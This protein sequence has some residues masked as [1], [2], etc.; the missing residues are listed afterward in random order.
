VLTVAHVSAASI[1]VSLA[2][3]THGAPGST[4][5]NL[6]TEGDLDWGVF[7]NS[8]LAPSTRMSGG[9]G[10][11]SMAYL[12]GASE[13][14]YNFYAQNSYSWTNGDSP[15]SGSENLTT[16]ADLGSNG[17]GIRSTFSIATAGTYRLKFYATTSDTN[18]SAIASLASGG[19]T[20]TA[21]GIETSGL[22]KYEFTVD[23][24]TDGS[25]TLTLDVVK[26]GGSIILAYEA[27]TLAA[28]EVVP[29]PNLNIDSDFS[30][31]NASTAETFQIPYSNNGQ[32][33]LTVSGVTVG[34]TDAAYFTVASYDASL[35]AGV[36]G[37]VALDF[38][39]VAGD[40]VYNATLTIASNDS[41]S[42]NTVVNLSVNSGNVVSGCVMDIFIV[43]GQSNA[44]GQGEVSTLSPAQAAA[45]DV[46][47]FCSWHSEGYNAETQQYFSDWADQTEAGYT[48]AYTFNNNFG[49]GGALG[50]D[51]DAG[52]FGPSSWFGPEVGFAARALELNLTGGNQLGIIKY[53]VDGSGLS[54]ATEIVAASDWDVSAAGYRQGDAW[55][56]FQ[57]AI[58]DAVAKLEADGISPNFKGMIWWQGEGGTSTPALNNFITA[59]RAHLANNYGLE[60]PLDFPVVITTGGKMIGGSTL[61]SGVAGIDDDVTFVNADHY[62]QLYQ[63]HV[64]RGSEGSSDHTGNGVNDMYDIGEAYAEALATVVEPTEFISDCS[65]G[66]NNGSEPAPG[67][68]YYVD[69]FMATGQSNAFYPNDQ[70]E[71]NYYGLGRGAQA[72]LSASGLF[73]NPTVVM[74]GAPGWAIAGWGGEW[75]GPDGGPNRNYQQQFFG[76]WDYGDGNGP[77][78]AAL[79]V[80]LD[81]IIAAGNTP[82]FRGLFWFQGES[83]GYG[84]YANNN[85]P[86]QATSQ[87]TY[88]L[89]WNGILEQLDADLQAAG[90]DHTQYKF[91]V[92]TVAESGSTINNILN[93]IATSG[94]YN[95][96]G[97]IYDAINSPHHGNNDVVDAYGD[98]HDYDHYAVGQANAQLFIDTYPPT[99]TSGYI[100]TSINVDDSITT[101]TVSEGVVATPPAGVNTATRTFTG[102]PTV[103][104]ATAAATYTAEYTQ[105]S[106][107][108]DIVDLFIAT[109]Q[110]NAYWPV[111]RDGEVVTGT[112]EFGNG[113]KDALVASGLFSNPAV[114]IDGQPGQEIAQWYENGTPQWLYQ[115][116][117]FG[118]YASTTAGLEAKI[119]EIIANGD[120]PRFRG[121]FWF[122]GESDGE[123]AG[124]S[125]T[126]EAVYTA[127]WNGILTQLAADLGS[128]D[129]NFVMNTV[130]NSGTR[131]N[132]TLTNITNADSRGV[133]FDTQVAPYRTNS[134]DIHG[135]DHYAVGQANAQL[136]IDTFMKDFGK[137]LCVGDSITEGSATRPAG[138]GN[139]SWRYAFW[140]QLVDN[141]V[142]YEFVGTSTYNHDYNNEEAFSV[143]P[144]YEGESFVNRHE[145]YW[146]LGAVHLASSLPGSLSTLK[147]Q[148]ETPDTAVV[149]L[150]GND[151]FHDP[152]V[153]AETVRDRIKTIVDTL[154]G[155]SG[156]NGNPNISVLLVS[157]LPRFTIDGSGNYTVP[158]TQSDHFT[159][160][161]NLLES[162]A[163]AESTAS[164]TVTYL[165]LATTF[166][167]TADVFYDGVHPNGTGE[168]LIADGIYSALNANAG[169]V[170][171]PATADVT[172]DG[173]GTDNLWTTASNWSGNTLPVDGDTVAIAN[174]DTVDIPGNYWD[175]PT[176]V[177][178]NV[179]GNSQIVNN[180]AAARLYGGMTFNFSSGS[181]M[182]GAY[183]DLQ[184]GILNF[185]DGA[186]FTPNS[187]QHRLTTI[188]GLTL[189]STGFTTLTPGILRQ[190]TDEDWG[191]VTF[192]LD[193]S[194]YEVSNGTTVELIDYSGH[195]SAYGGTFNPTVNLTAGDSGL[196]GTLSFDTASSKVIYTF[197]S[198]AVT[199]TYTITFINVDDTETTQTVD[200]GEVATPPAGVDTATRTFTGWP[201]I[202]A[203]TADATYTALYDVNAATADVIWD[204]G[205]AD[206]LWTTAAN[207][208]GDTL[209][210]TGDSVLVGSSAT[211]T[212][213]NANFSSLEIASG[214][215]VSFADEYPSNKTFNISGVLDR[216]A[217]NTVLR[218][219]GSVFNL[220]SS[221]SFGANIQWMDLGTNSR[222]SFAD[223]ASFATATTLELRG[224][225]TFDFTL[226]AT[227]FTTLPLGT[228]ADGGTAGWSDVTFN[229]DVSAYDTSNGLSI[230]LMDFASHTGDFGGSF[231]P[232]VNV[233]DGGTG[234]GAA[235]SFDAATSRII[236][237]IDA[238]GNDAPVAADISYAADG[239]DPVTITLS[240]TDS[241]SDP[242]TYTVVSGPSAGTLSGAAPNLIYTY[243]GSSFE[244]DSFTFKANDGVDDS[245]IA[246]VSI[247]PVPQNVGDLWGSL[248]NRIEN[249][250]LNAGTHTTWTEAHSNGSGDTITISRITYELGTLT[251]TQNSATPVIAGYY[252]RPTGGTNLPGL[253]QNH[254]G[255]QNA[256]SHYAKYL[257]EQ[258][259]AA[260]SIN[261]GGY[262][263]ENRNPNE[264]A[265]PEGQLHPNT[266]WDGLPAGFRRENTIDNPLEYPV[267]EAIFYEFI[268]PKIYSDGQTLYDFPHPLNSTWTLNGYAVRRAITYL[269]SLPEVD[270][271]KIGVMGWSRGGRTTVMSSTD[272]R[273][274]VLAPGGGGT[275]YVYEDFWG[276]P[277]TARLMGEVPEDIELFNSTVADQAYWHYISA[278]LLFLNAS[279]DF[280]AP[281]DL[282][283]KS[284]SIHG[285]GLNEISP[286]NI[287][288]A[289]PHF[290]HRLTDPALA[291][292]M[293]W[294]RHHL[295]GDVEFPGISDS[296][297]EMTT[298]GGVPVFKVYPDTSTSYAIDSVEIYYGTDRDSRTRFWRDAGAVD[299]G[300]HWEAALP[301]FDAEDMLAA[302]A[303]ITYDVGFT[304]AVAYS[305]PTDLIKVASKVHTYYPTGVDSD[306][307]LPADLNTD[308]HQ[309]HSLDPA[310]LVANGLRETAEISYAIDDP[311][312]ASGFHDWFLINETNTSVWQFYTRKIS[313]PS[314]RGG[315]GALLTFDLSADATNTL[316]VKIVVDGWSENSETTYHA[317]VPVVAGFNAISLSV[318][319]FKRTDNT[320]LGSW[321]SAKFI[322]FGSGKAFNLN[323]IEWSG[324]IPTFA[325][326]AWSGGVSTL[327]RGITSTW[328]ST[329][330]LALSNDAIAQDADGDGQSSGAE[331][332]AGTNPTDSSSVFRVE[333][334]ALGAG[335][336]V[337]NWQAVAGSLMPME[338][339]PLPRMVLLT[340]ATALMT[341]SPLILSRERSQP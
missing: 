224:A 327:D 315:E 107:G 323:T 191:D 218:P 232:T 52:A 18:L 164:S 23:F 91:V 29:V 325:N 12:G 74:Q 330:G 37:N 80:K 182:S 195:D 296:E 291:A 19:V 89:R 87:A 196:S 204:G 338:K 256:D 244:T 101:Q 35:A 98:L 212:N 324:S 301:I 133:L 223:G 6:T 288:V 238:A 174:G 159:D 313:H 48:R 337:L 50:G 341:R 189:S 197:D 255:G 279:N 202:L 150:G 321:S 188:Y 112:Y 316:Q 53:G 22:Q 251:G 271:S 73:S 116:Q 222:L 17:A 2:Q 30:F 210:T 86:A 10:F 282:A 229:I 198:E 119:N 304:Q 247:V 3:S 28:V 40:R 206:N 168:Q 234:I 110:S 65:G 75:V 264:P 7:A 263:L 153:T 297:L 102:W 246:T 334:S 248:Q 332:D 11:T 120:T 46:K 36:S 51:T 78:S 272:P 111:N 284:L 94:T 318:S 194:N 68:G 21:T 287:L 192:N 277:D 340:L 200:G 239:S 163:T 322:G 67:G 141:N 38:N 8:T 148:S 295:I 205:G 42:P 13:N 190:G 59:V 61:E 257:A 169:S 249:D 273:I 156:S 237:T 278:P 227:G 83:D 219:G 214:A 176:G 142:S 99:P 118:T 175:L 146:G 309:I 124:Q 231:N 276:L 233:I 57:A 303:V 167:N 329:Y 130:G 157:I 306:Y 177:T 97:T 82:R 69:V 64:G 54:T 72:T 241:E 9:S 114:V 71:A 49:N 294:L 121:V 183:I 258:G 267:T 160:I 201:T 268:N 320:P 170:T 310:V 95:A 308:V 122:Q 109:G 173:G 266:N 208:S 302:H 186:T 236:A 85:D 62:G 217:P 125:N 311:S 339:S 45:H 252:A 147:N 280:Y 47:F 136:F 31:T 226:S 128:S 32:L 289:E 155:D 215:S 108:G 39:P 106:G 166:N 44:N 221:G 43:A 250:P 326:L 254:G 24:E 171:S 242:L 103:A 265:S 299:R 298:A 203:A 105:N 127:R 225:T 290:N 328:L 253:V 14:F 281:F 56:G 235:L 307:S 286:A 262:H 270:D 27:F 319:D 96:K 185:E 90:V 123:A 151:I 20:H 180:I 154:Q 245:N 216:D 259:Y 16:N 305:N 181:G 137:I 292:R 335:E 139:W 300:T 1:N 25:D 158:V 187:I 143:Y 269:Q 144:D 152:S 4:P 333:T 145:A 132:T 243:T 283:T 81:E 134:E 172:W 213:A 220:P 149:F 113:V 209:P 275:G 70:G 79:E 207:W 211:V 115:K 76:E 184:N 140:K 55:R 135:Y 66:G 88:E 285:A 100:I 199:T 15:V 60:N 5:I 138:E 228:L 336:F 178:I 331:Y 193:V 92:N 84:P 33:G 117:F 131:I 274:T 293:L 129:F 104:P 161:N 34:G 314:Y 26:A 230:V 260:L 312:G 126:S 58:A 165:D 41:D 179:S 63:T 162:L 240:A 77:V 317:A 93:Y 261:W